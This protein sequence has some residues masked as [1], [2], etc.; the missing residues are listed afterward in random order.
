MLVMTSSTA[1]SKSSLVTKQSMMEQ[2]SWPPLPLACT[3]KSFTALSSAW[4]A[5]A[6]AT[7]AMAAPENPSHFFAMASSNSEYNGRLDNFFVCREKNE[8]MYRLLFF[9]GRLWFTYQYMLAGSR[10]CW[11][12]TDQET[13]CRMHNLSMHSQNANPLVYTAGWRDLKLHFKAS[14]T[15]KSFNE[16]GMLVGYPSTPKKI[17][18]T[19]PAR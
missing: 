14:S 10:A 16:R 19:Y 13:A 2:V 11:S 1:Q 5:A 4:L 18:S 6:L 9:H 8:Y 15:Q 17:E 12:I 3:E 7:P